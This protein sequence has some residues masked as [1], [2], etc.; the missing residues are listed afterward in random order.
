MT[1]T[2]PLSPTSPT[3]FREEQDRSSW[4]PQPSHQPTGKS[5]PWVAG[6]SPSQKCGRYIA[7][8]K[9]SPPT[10]DPAKLHPPPDFTAST[11]PCRPRDRDQMYADGAD[12]IYHAAVGTGLACS[13]RQPSRGTGRSGRSVDSA[14]SGRRRTRP[15]SRHL[16]E[17]KPSTSRVLVIKASRVRSS[18]AFGLRPE[19]RWRRLRAVRDNLTPTDAATAR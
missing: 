8:A 2:T 15:N 13:R 16:P 6:R 19:G 3:C 18:P 11:P 14:P 12:V 1:P 7:G 5:F 10:S 17:L 4:A 9:R